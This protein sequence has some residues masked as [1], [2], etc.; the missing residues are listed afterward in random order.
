M[1]EKFH[2]DDRAA[3][4]AIFSDCERYRYVLTREWDPSG[5]RVLFVMLNPSTADEIKNELTRI[6]AELGLPVTRDRIRVSKLPNKTRVH[7]QYQ[8]S[9]EWLPG[10]T[11]TWEVDEVA[12]SVVAGLDS[13]RFLILPHTEV[14]DFFCGKAN[15][16]DR[17]LQSMQGLRDRMLQQS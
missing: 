15:D 2:N 16:Y 1:I 5:K 17:W 3:S 14:A 11:Y 7:V 13:E 9:V 8:L 4:S 12:E 6:A 10:N